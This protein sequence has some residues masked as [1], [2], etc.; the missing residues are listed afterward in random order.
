[1]K[2]I[3]IFFTLFSFIA[4]L[5]GCVTTSG[6]QTAKEAASAT[7]SIPPNSKFS[8]I[9]IG[10]PMQQ[11]YDIIGNPSDSKAYMTGKAFIPWYFGSD[12]SRREAFYKGEG[13]ITFAGG[14]GIGGGAFKVYRI[15]YDPTEDGY[16]NQ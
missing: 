13:R 3:L 11:V 14:A 16:N 7:N 5:S 2:K 6:K 9:S 4:V 10:M 15:I 12:G 1:M 8:K